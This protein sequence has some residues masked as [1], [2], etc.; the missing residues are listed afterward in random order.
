MEGIDR[1][2][3]SSRLGIDADTKPGNRLVSTSIHS[4]VRNREKYFGEFQKTEGRFRVKK[5]FFKCAQNEA[6]GE[7]YVKYSQRFKELTGVDCPF[8]FGDL[9]KFPGY[10]LSNFQFFLVNL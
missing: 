6:G 3:I 8:R 2:E 4:T 7:L 1:Y 9:L 10:N 5:Y